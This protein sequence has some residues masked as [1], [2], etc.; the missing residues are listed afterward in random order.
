MGHSFIYQRMKISPFNNFESSFPFF[1]LI[2]LFSLSF[3]LF[4]LLSFFLFLILFYLFFFFFLFFFSSYF[5][6]AFS[7]FPPPR[8]LP[9]SSRFP[10]G[11]ASIGDGGRPQ[12]SSPPCPTS[13][14]FTSTGR[15]LPLRRVNRSLP[16]PPALLTLLMSSVAPPV[17]PAP[18]SPLSDREYQLFFA[19]LQPPWK[20]ELSCRLRQA[21]GCLSPAVL[22]RD[23]EE[24]HGR[25]PGG[26]GIGGGQ[27]SSWSGAG[28]FSAP[29]RPQDGGTGGGMRPFGGL[30]PKVRLG[31]GRSTPALCEGVG[32][33][34]LSGH[35]F[36]CCTAFLEK[37]SFS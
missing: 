28:R 36:Q 16:S 22:P 19:S 35:P 10:Q 4:F 31:A 18:G 27:R 21:R 3:F 5:F 11:P 24:N 32:L 13:F 33:C 7:F 9:Q 34:R 6:P 25:V 15:L 14:S 37:K 26:R 29:K 12:A 20:A 23:Q 1:L 8:L 2:F 17:P 30:E